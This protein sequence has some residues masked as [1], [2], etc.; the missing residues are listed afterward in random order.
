MK[1]K[2]TRGGVRGKSYE[3]AICSGYALDGGLFVPEALPSIDSAQ[4]VQLA[5]LATF[6]DV[7]AEVLRL[8]ID[9]SEIPGAELRKL[10]WS[11]FKGFANPQGN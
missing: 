1:Y 10:V 8:F 3:E 7:A 11:S 9:D 5:G 6:Q 4:L 2:S